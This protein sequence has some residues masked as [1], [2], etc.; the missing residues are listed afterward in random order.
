MHGE[1]F[2]FFSGGTVFHC[3]DSLLTRLPLL[4]SIWELRGLGILRAVK[5]ESSIRFQPRLHPEFTQSP[6]APSS[7]PVPYDRASGGGAGDGDAERTS[8]ADPS[9]R[10]R[11]GERRAQHLGAE[12]N[13]SGVATPL[14]QQHQTQR[15]V[16]H[17][18]AR[19]QLSGP[20]SSAP[21]LG[22]TTLQ[23]RLLTP[24][25]AASPFVP[26][27]RRLQLSLSL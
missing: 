16:W 13:L 26:T 4:L 15:V 7:P 27:P 6:W 9:V 1:H 24:A 21:D 5:L 18:Q 20:P 3:K 19:N 23:H 2:F 14:Y 10:V 22:A 25:S 12:V 17:N 8:L 11:V